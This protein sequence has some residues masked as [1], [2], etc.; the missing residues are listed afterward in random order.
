MGNHDYFTD[1]EAF[2]RELEQGGLRLLRNKGFIIERTGG[3]LYIAGVDD[4]W[5]HRDDLERALRGRP[6]DAPVVLLAHDPALFPAAAARG[7]ALTLAGH[8]HGGQLAAPIAAATLESG[9]AVDPVHRG[10]L[11][12]RRFRACTSTAA[13]APPGRPSGWACGPR[14]R[15]SRWSPPTKCLAD[16]LSHLAEDVIRDAS[17]AR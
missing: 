11:P 16:R 15:C 5:T 14:S 9:P 3:R 17:E 10:L 8:T 7:I 4:T 13:W 1:G 12:G 2:A 6:A